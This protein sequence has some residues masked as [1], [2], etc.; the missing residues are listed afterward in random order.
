MRNKYEWHSRKAILQGCVFPK[1]SLGMTSSYPLPQNLYDL[2]VCSVWPA[3]GPKPSWAWVL[4]LITCLVLMVTT[5][6]YCSSSVSTCYPLFAVP[7]HLDL[8]T[9]ILILHQRK[10]RFREDLYLI[11]SLSGI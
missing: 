6:I 4:T 10:Q 5:T 1:E 2:P 11:N 3:P 8:Y 9:S 7:N